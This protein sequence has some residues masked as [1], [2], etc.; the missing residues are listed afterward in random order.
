MCYKKDV[1]PLYKPDG[2]CAECLNC[3]YLKNA[4]ES[5]AHAR[6][7]L[8]ISLMAFIVITCIIW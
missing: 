8:A 5:I 4:R 7:A 3:E 2:P 6:I 1:C